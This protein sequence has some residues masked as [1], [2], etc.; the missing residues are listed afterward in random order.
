MR[1]MLVIA[2]AITLI[3]STDAFGIAPASFRNTHPS[4][5]RHFSRLTMVAAEDHGRRQALRGITAG[6]AGSLLSW[7]LPASAGLDDKRSVPLGARESRRGPAGVNKPEL[8]P[9]GP[10]V[11]IIDLEKFLAKSQIKKIDEKLARLEEDTGYKF[12][13]LCQR[14]PETPGLAIKDYWGLDDKS[15]V[16]IVDRGTSKSGMTNILN[17]NVGPGVDLALPPI[18]FTRLR[19]YFGTAFYVKDNGEDTAILNSIEAIIGCLRS[20]FCTDVPQDMKDVANKGV[21]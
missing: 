12:R 17:F 6:V 16:M 11:N 10:K 21:F 15:I 1:I 5:S 13:I 8:L 14:Y 20:G 3:A 19:N 2:A 7:A 4:N 9:E 18:F